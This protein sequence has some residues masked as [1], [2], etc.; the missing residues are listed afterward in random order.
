MSEL[1]RHTL[2]HADGRRLYVYGDLRGALDARPGDSAATYP[3]PELHQRFDAL[4]GAWVAI[5][6]ARNTRPQD[7]VAS[8]A[9]GQA[10]PLC[11]GGVEVP[12]SYRAA[13]FENR[14]PTFVAHPPPVPDDPLLAASLGRCEVVLYTESHHGSLATLPPEEVARV[15]AVWRDRSADLWAEPEHAFVMAFENRGEAVGATLDHPHGQIYAFSDLPPLIAERV[16]VLARH[17]AATGDCLTCEVLARDAKAPE[18]TIAANASFSVTVPYAA[19][20]PFEVDVRATRHGLRRLGDLEPGERSD[21]AAALAE[22]VARYDGLFGF[23]LSYLMVIMEAPGDTPDWHLSVAFMPP[24]RSARKLKVRASV[25]TATGVFIND[26]LPEA[27]AAQM[28]EVAVAP[29]PPGAFKV[30]EIVRTTA[31]TE[32]RER[33]QT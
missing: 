26:T 2:T 29:V 15:V 11:P 1:A 30:P 14:F 5:S 10:C 13:V 32:P 20:W 23:A 28:A 7:G 21:L 6:P 9:A 19:R 17:R 3:P 16:G 27:S 33:E 4:T 8:S 25:E 12:F 31:A 24:H 18:R 22:V